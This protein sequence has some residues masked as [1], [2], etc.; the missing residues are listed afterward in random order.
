MVSYRLSH[1]SAEG[2]RDVPSQVLGP[3]V[4]P[5]P[6]AR[7]AG[8]RAGTALPSRTAPSSGLAR[9]SALKRAETPPTIL[10]K[11]LGSLLTAFPALG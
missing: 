1:R 10:P 7:N 8:S 6:A 5:I 4:R 9:S 3:N 11:P 2:C